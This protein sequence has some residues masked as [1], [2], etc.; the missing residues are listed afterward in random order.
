MYVV[1]QFEEDEDEGKPMDIWNYY[2]LHIYLLILLQVLC[3]WISI[4]VDEEEE[5]PGDYQISFHW[6][7]ENTEGEVVLMDN[8]VAQDWAGD[9]EGSS[10]IEPIVQQ[11]E[12]DLEVHYTFEKM[13]VAVENGIQT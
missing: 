6:L 2:V 13:N 5:L 7:K 11:M 3:K 8:M 1:Q 9:D 12:K 4:I 10:S